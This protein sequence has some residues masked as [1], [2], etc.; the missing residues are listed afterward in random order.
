MVRLAADC[1]AASRISENVIEVT[2]MLLPAIVPSSWLVAPG[3]PKTC[4][5]MT[6]RTGRSQPTRA[7][8]AA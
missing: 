8:S 3:S 4:R 6:S 7:L 2:V 1:R 5:C